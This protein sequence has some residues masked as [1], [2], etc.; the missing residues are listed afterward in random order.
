MEGAGVGG[1]L[2]GELLETQMPL[3]T[4]GERKESMGLSVARR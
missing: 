3:L 1:W 4:P 2:S